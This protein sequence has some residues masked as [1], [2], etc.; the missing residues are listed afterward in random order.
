[1]AVEAEAEWVGAARGLGDVPMVQGEAEVGELGEE[2]HC[3]VGLEPRC[4]VEMSEVME[5]VQQ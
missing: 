5:G 4:G 1:M 2:L 3:R